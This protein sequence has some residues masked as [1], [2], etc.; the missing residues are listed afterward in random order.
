MLRLD[1]FWQGPRR[2]TGAIKMLIG[3][4]ILLEFL[5]HRIPFQSPA[6]QSR[7]VAQMA[8]RGSTVA[9]LD[10]LDRVLAALDRV[11]EVPRVVGDE[12]YFPHIRFRF[13]KNFLAAASQPP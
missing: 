5:S 13:S 2:A 4:G 3:F 1:F 7:D 6:K 9:D 8:E 12:A 10:G 11:E